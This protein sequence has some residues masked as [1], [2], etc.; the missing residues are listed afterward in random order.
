MAR[1]SIHRIH[2]A[3][4]HLP[5]DPATRTDYS[6][7]RQQPARRSAAQEAEMFNSVRRQSAAVLF[8]LSM[9][10][11]AGAGDTCSPVMEWN[12]YALQATMAAAQGALPQIRS[13]AIVH[14]SMHDAVNGITGE[15]RTYLPAPAATVGAS[16]EAA[17]IAAASY[18]L[19]QL[20]PSQVR[21]T[22][23]RPSLVARR[24]ALT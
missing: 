12:Q 16:A 22:S 20:I 5:Q 14:A 1:E 6:P 9:A 11:T 23:H 8:C 13:M 24:L 15:Y 10:G 4:P 3:L 17:A 19:M 7:P 18:A 2:I 21:A